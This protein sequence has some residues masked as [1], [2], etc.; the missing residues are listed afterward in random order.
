MLTKSTTLKFYKRRDIQEAI[1]EHAAGREFS[2]RYGETFGKRPDILQY[3][4]EIIELALQ[5]ATSFHCSEERW[6]NPSALRTDMRRE[7]MDALRQG[8]D[9]MLDIDCAVLEYSTIA[10]EVIIRFL[11]YCGVRD[12]SVKFSGNKGFHIGVPFEAF[13]EKVGEKETKYLFPEAPK[14]LAFYVKEHIKEELGRKI[15]EME[16]N[17]FSAVVEK[18][19]KS[20]EEIIYHKKDA[21][22]TEVPFLNAEPFLEID[23]ILLSSRHLY[24]MPYS[25]HEKSGLVSL[26]L[27]PSKV[28][29]FRREMAHPDAILAPMFPFLPRTVSGESARNLLLQAWDFKA[30]ESMEELAGLRVAASR[31]EEMEIKSPITE[32]FFP[33]C[34]QK[35]C[36]G[37]EDGKKRGV[38]CLLNFLGKVGWS[39]KDIEE[40]VKKW[41]REKN[42]VP[43]REVYIKS[44][45]KHFNPGERLPPNCGHEGYYESMGVAC[46]AEHCRKFKNP[47]NYTLWKWR[48]W[49]REKEEGERK[50]G[51]ER[52]RAGSIKNLSQ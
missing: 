9:L 29:A 50:L 3:P 49:M 16:K 30:E 31:F 5:N 52:F 2:V 14:K 32:E 7:E 39:R 35:I 1:V 10:A 17:D 24:R 46:Q 38:F 11:R 42:R 48:R 44:Q 19:K 20:K 12:I 47:V 45:L 6:N 26:P 13:P 51:R 37:L 4:Q 23:T 43:L 25:L 22:G 40:F 15:M 27:D 34:M 18:T 33:P 21:L 28:G 41:N 36:S 8:W